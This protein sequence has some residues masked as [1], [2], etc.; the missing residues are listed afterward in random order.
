MVHSYVACIGENI[1]DLL[2]AAR[3]EL[4]RWK[5]IKDEELGTG[6]EKAFGHACLGTSAKI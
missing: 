3:N 5:G 1:K 2:I 4:L 6:Q